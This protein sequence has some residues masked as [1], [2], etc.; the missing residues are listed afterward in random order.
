MQIRKCNGVYS[1]LMKTSNVE[2]EVSKYEFSFCYQCEKFHV[3]VE[4]GLCELCQKI[5][6]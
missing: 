2:S 5:H 4:D 3:N 1:N 6:S